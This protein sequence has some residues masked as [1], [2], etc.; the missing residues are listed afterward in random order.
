MLNILSPVIM[1]SDVASG[2]FFLDFM[3]KKAYGV[4]GKECSSEVSAE[5]FSGA[6]G[7]KEETFFEM[8]YEQINEV[9][10][11]ERKLAE[12]NSKHIWRRP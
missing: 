8:P 10:G 7:K 5:I 2:I 11:V 4:D 6:Q 12:D 1:D 3:A 9:L